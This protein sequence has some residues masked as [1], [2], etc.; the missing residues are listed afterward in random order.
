MKHIAGDFSKSNF[1]GRMDNIGVP[2]GPLTRP[3]GNWE[4]GAKMFK[5]ELKEPF[6]ESSDI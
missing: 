2:Q 4:A 6:L 5:I 1:T 3:L